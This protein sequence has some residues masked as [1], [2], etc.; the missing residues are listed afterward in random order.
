MPELP[1]K[2]CEL[3]RLLKT[4]DKAAFTQIY[5]LY[6]QSLYLNLLKLLKFEPAAEELL[7]D[8]FITLWEKR[9]TIQIDTHLSGY[10]FG[11][12]QHKAQDFFRK[13]KRDRK[14]HDYIR[15]L[16]TGEFE[17]V[18]AKLLRQEELD[19]LNNAINR[20]SPQRKQVFQLCK[21]EGKSYQ[22]VSHILGISPSTINDHIVKATRFIR[23]FMLA[24]DRLTTAYLPIFLLLYS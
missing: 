2:D 3:L 10:L 18:E 20:L 12:A 13:L 19:L 21:L 7:Q 4:G 22:E 24:Q 16:A 14:L 17:S 15:E 5:E 8:I 6:S 9:T 11:I 23:D 1:D